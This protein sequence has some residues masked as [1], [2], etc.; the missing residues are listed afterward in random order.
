MVL[1][2]KTIDTVISGTV[3]KVCDFRE[4]DQLI[5]VLTSEGERICFLAKSV[6][7]IASKNR[8]SCQ[9]FSK[10]EYELVYNPK[11]HL[12]LL[13]RA[14]YLANFVIRAKSIQQLS[15][16]HF[17]SEVC[18]KGY[19]S[20]DDKVSFYIL[21]EECLT[22]LH[23]NMDGYF[24]I[25]Y[26]LIKLY[27]LTGL[28]LVLDSCVQ[29]HSKKDIVTFTASKGGY[30]CSACDDTK[31]Y[32]SRESLSVLRLMSYCN[33]LS[34]INLDITVD[35]RPIYKEL[36]IVLLDYGHFVVRSLDDY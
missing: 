2:Q 34:S 23:A 33:N 6:K 21:V 4:Y 19:D 15:A 28:Q 24:V 31:R 10:G 18:L 9:L 35:F 29:C 8:V 20:I 27:E 13:K 30:V 11:T 1:M 14:Q 5:T 32:F 36:F 17:I 16:F 22:S 7:K 12:Y 25:C 3:I 26:F